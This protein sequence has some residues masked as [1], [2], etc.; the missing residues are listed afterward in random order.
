MSEKEA[1]CTN[2]AAAGLRSMK[3]NLDTG[4]EVDNNKMKKEQCQATYMKPDS[5]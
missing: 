2:T 1:T 5:L 3:Q 4:V